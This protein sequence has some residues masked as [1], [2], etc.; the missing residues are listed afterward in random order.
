[1]RTLD[2]SWYSLSKKQGLTLKLKPETVMEMS[3]P[4]FIGKRQQHLYS[5]AETELDFTPKSD[6]EKAGLIIF[7]DEGHFY[8]VAKS[9][10]QGKAVLQLYKSKPKEKDMELLAEVPLTNPSGKTGVRI[11]SKGDTYSFQV[12]TDAKNWTLLKD[13]VDGK[14]LSTKVAGGFI[15]CVYGMYATSSGEP[16]SNSASFSYLKYQGDDPMYK[17]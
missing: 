16:S 15:G 9:M 5:T 3:N 4:A 8:F 11:T 2:K 6:R 1:M 12:S 13:N 7:Q 14:F 10:S 17:K